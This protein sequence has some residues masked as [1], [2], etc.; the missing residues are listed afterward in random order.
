M[1]PGGNVYRFLIFYFAAYGG[2]HL[3]FYSK[4]KKAFRLS[5]RSP[6]TISIYLLIIL[7][8]PLI[9]RNLESSGLEILPEP[10]SSA[11]YL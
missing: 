1:E 2:A 3:Y 6:L 4:L 11:R 7:L 5:R 8:S 10:L 9:A